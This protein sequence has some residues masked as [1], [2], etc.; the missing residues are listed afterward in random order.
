MKFRKIFFRVLLVLLCLMAAVLVV[1]AVFNYVE[2]RRLAKTLADLKAQGVPLTVKDLI[3]PCPEGENGAVLWKAAEEL[4]VFEGEDTKLIAGINLN[5]VRNLPVAADA[6]AQASRLIEKNRRVLDLV[7]E[8]AGKPCFQYGDTGLKFY[9]KR[10]PNAIKMIRTMR[11]L[12]LESLQLAEKGDL[13]ASL[14][15]LRTGLR[16]APKMAEESTLITF[17]IALADAKTCLFFLN[18]SLS[19]REAGEALLTPLL[20]DLGP[21]LVD[22]WKAHL[23][24]GIRGERVL[25]LSV[26]LPPSPSTLQEAFGGKGLPARLYYWLTLPLTKRDI[27]LNLPNY[28][29]LEARALSP[30]YQTRDFWKPYK[31]HMGDLPWYAILSKNFVPGMETTFMKVATFDAL[32]LTA[33]AGLACRVFK[34]RTGQYPESLEALV[35]GLLKEVPTDPFT[36]KPLV[37]RREGDGFIVYS[38]GSNQKDDGGRTTWEI[39]QLVMEKDDDW[40]WKETR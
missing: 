38:L 6:W 15:K 32:V 3:A 1:R 23:K 13:A 9:E 31:D 24:A 26:G 30:Y 14:D 37:Y 19:G 5:L 17:L 21:G 8:I 10:I 40:A 36:G 25:Y 27:R 4:F 16:F 11:L 35:P 12:G 22:S 34:G 29:E 39:T 33:R 2:G 7:P 18:R 20:E 28:A